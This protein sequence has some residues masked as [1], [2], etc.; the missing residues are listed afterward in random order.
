MRAY[1]Y[2][3]ARS[4]DT[5]GKVGILLPVPPD[6]LLGEGFGVG[7]HV[8]ELSEQ[9]LDILLGHAAGLGFAI[10]PYNLVDRVQAVRHRVERLVDVPPVAVRV[11]GRYVDEE[12][13]AP[14][15]LGQIEHELCP[16]NVDRQGVLDSGV[17]F[18][19][20]RAVVHD[21]DSVHER[22]SILGR[23]S[24][25]FQKEIALDGRHFFLKVRIGRPE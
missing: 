19:V 13:H 20:G 17:E 7:V 12:L 25:I 9:G 10:P 5:Q 21:V 18:Y 15:L 6:Q 8:R 22:A 23:Y 24:Q 2:T 16:E 3:Y 14:A 4:V 11:G 1:S